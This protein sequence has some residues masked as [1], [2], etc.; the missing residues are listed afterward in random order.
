MFGPTI[1]PDY[2]SLIRACFTLAPAQEAVF[3][4]EPPPSGIAHSYSMV[5]G[6]PALSLAAFRD[7][8]RFR[9]RISPDS[10]LPIT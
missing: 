5:A 9:V 7:T 1:P 4:T 10:A 3:W 8:E 6:W 2:L